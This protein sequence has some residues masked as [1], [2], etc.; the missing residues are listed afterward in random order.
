M[1][2]VIFLLL[3]LAVMQCSALAQIRIAVPA[4]AKSTNLPPLIEAGFS[5]IYKAID[6]DVI[7]EYL[8]VARA[9]EM[10]QQGRIDALGY[11][12]E[13]SAF[14]SK[15]L[16]KI[17]ESLTDVRLFVACHKEQKCSLSNTDKYVYVGEE[18]FTEG[19]CKSRGLDCL[20][21]TDERTALKTVNSGLAD[22]YIL[23]RVNVGVGRCYSQIGM[24]LRPITGQHFELYHYVS[25]ELASQAQKIADSIKRAKQT[26]KYIQ[27]YSHCEKDIAWERP[28]Q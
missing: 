22:G 2:R 9:Y 3:S 14:E 16:F 26:T 18:L 24:E 19:Y 10:A 21:V 12:T 27:G 25:V 17:P 6:Q 7:I 13:L 15:N 23:E 28:L 20:P 4:H 1:F 8:P 11:Y 5:D